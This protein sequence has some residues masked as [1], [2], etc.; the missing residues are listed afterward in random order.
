MRRMGLLLAAGST[1]LAVSIAQA[2]DLMDYSVTLKGDCQY[3]IV[4][5][6]DDCA[7][8]AVYTLFKNGKYQFQFVDGHQNSYA[9]WGRKD[10]Q[11]D[12]SNLYSNIDT[13]ETTIDGKKVVDAKA[14]GGCNTKITP[15]GDK[16][17]YIDCS[18][19]NAKNV[20]F[21]FRISNITDVQRMLTQ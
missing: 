7:D 18:V 10:R 13:M 21:K 2:G 9:F 1:L 16:F 4:M 17:V 12:Q 6:W 8:K 19:S 20:L 5:G 15:S 11:V 3:Q 14:M